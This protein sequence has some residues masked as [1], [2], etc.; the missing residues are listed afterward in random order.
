MTKF[1]TWA[2]VS[3]VVLFF[4]TGAVMGFTGYEPNA[5]RTVERIDHV[6]AVVLH[7]PG[8]YSVITENPTTKLEGSWGETTS[9]THVELYADI[10][11]D[12]YGWAEY[13]T[14]SYRPWLRRESY[15]IPNAPETLIVHYHGVSDLRGGGWNHGKFGSGQTRIFN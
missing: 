11:T 2:A 4:L 5:H 10:P 12:E 1:I 7:E 3:L 14:R 13:R 6:V 9:S 15:H 8:R